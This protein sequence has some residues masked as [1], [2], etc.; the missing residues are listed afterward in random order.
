[1]LRKENIYENNK[2]VSAPVP[3]TTPAWPVC[4]ALSPRSLVPSGTAPQPR[5]GPAQQVSAWWLETLLSSAASPEPGDPNARSS[6][7][8]GAPTLLVPFFLLSGGWD[9]APIQGRVGARGGSGRT[10]PG[11]GPGGAEALPHSGDRCPEPSRRPGQGSW[12][13]RL[14]PRAL[15][16]LGPRHLP[17]ALLQTFP[18]PASVS[19][20]QNMPHYGDGLLPGEA[21]SRPAQ[22]VHHWPFSLT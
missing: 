5:E 8:S 1:M 22:L 18:A 16:G 9:T 15:A 14:Q 13:H 6:L 17:A 3:A 4:P 21:D 12:A 11:A 19:S 10:S 20:L 7:W 2:L